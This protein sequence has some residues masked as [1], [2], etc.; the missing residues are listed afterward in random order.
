VKV[1]RIARHY[2]AYDLVIYSA[3]PIPGGVALEHDDP[4]VARGADAHIVLGDTALVGAARALGPYRLAGDALLFEMPGVA[5]YRCEA[6]ARIT[7]ER[8][9][10]ASD[11]AIAGYLIAT[12]LPALL[13]MRGDIVLHMAA[14]VLPGMSGAIAFGGATGSGK[15]SILEQLVAAGASMVADDTMC[16]RFD[17]QDPISGPVVSGLP[18]GYFL[19]DGGAARTFRTVPPGQRV[20]SARLAG[21]VTLGSRMASGNAGFHLLTGASAFEA[22]L[23]A[24]HRPR[25]PTL[26]G[27]DKALLPVLARLSRD[28]PIHRWNRLEGQ[29]GVDARELMHLLHGA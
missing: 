21:V 22:L 29:K 23:A 16:V 28:L 26:L 18:G 1:P 7:V 6:G 14:A 4:R 10:G 5:R 19:A 8:S 9:A 11:A 17:G 3:L 13:W 12:A 2:L 24:R 20:S 15:S 27:R 25:V